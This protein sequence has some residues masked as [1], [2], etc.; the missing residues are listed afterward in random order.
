VNGFVA[1][2]A[3][4]P[5]LEE[6]IFCVVEGGASLRRSTADWFEANRES[7]LLSASLD[8]VVHAYAER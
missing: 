1:P 2:S 8:T 6:A 3:T 7:L 4:A 5:D